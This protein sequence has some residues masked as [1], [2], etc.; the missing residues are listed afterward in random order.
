MY[1]VKYSFYN[2]FENENTRDVII[3]FVTCPSIYGFWLPLSYLQIIL[4]S[5][6]MKK[7]HHNC[8]VIHVRNMYVHMQRTIHFGWIGQCFVHKVANYDI[9]GI[10]IFKNHIKNQGK[11]RLS[12]WVNRSCSTSATCRVTLVTNSVMS[13]EGRNNQIVIT[14]NGRYQWSFVS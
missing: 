10:F 1:F 9:S 2:H 11:L 7:R 14:S 13:H 4:N 3:H 8:S 12:E 5:K 6:R